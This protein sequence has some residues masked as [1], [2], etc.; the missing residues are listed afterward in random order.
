MSKSTVN[1]KV[2]SVF[3]RQFQFVFDLLPG[4][5]GIESLFQNI[6]VFGFQEAFILLR[7]LLH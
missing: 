2:L 1:K 6:I 4:F 7:V 3:A 5:I